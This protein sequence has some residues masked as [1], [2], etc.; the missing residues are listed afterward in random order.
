MGKECF[1][2]QPFSDNKFLKRYNDT[3][4]SRS[5]RFAIF[6]AR[7]DLQSVCCEAEEYKEMVRYAT[8]G[9]QTRASEAEKTN[10]QHLRV[11]GVNSLLG[12]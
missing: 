2:I 11:F 12:F 1:V 5:R 10:N 8:H 3:Y 7:A 9:L 4:K 6:P